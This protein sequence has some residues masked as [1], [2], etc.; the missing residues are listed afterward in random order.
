MDPTI[1]R[2][3]KKENK[4]LLQSVILCAMDIATIAGY[5]LIQL[6]PHT[7]WASMITNYIWLFCAGNPPLIYL[8]LNR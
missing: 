2:S 3:N 1:A 7:R 6:V 5:L 8:T 4:V